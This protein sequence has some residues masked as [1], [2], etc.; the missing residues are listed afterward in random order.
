MD[1]KPDKSYKH[2]NYNVRVYYGNKA[3]DKVTKEIVE[4]KAND[5]IKKLAQ[6]TK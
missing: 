1:R 3:H 6:T 5:Y 4:L 2:K